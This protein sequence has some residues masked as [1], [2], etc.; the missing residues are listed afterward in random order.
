MR[1]S[2]PPK[3][4]SRRPPTS[5]QGTQASSVSPP[6]PETYPI[7]VVDDDDSI[8]ELVRHALNAE[9]HRVV[10]AGSAEE[11]HELLGGVSQPPVLVLDL[12]LPGMT[13]LE[14][15]E[16]LVEERDDFEAILLT[17]HA[18]IESLM[19]A[20]QLGVFRCLRKPFDLH[21]LRQTI[22]GAAN[23]LFLR[24]DRRAQIAEVERRN[25]E[26]TAAL[27]KLRYSESKR[28]LAERLASIGQFASALAHEINGPLSYVGANLIAARESVDDLKELIERLDRGE[29][30]TQQAP[31]LRDRARSAV[32]TATEALDDGDSGV[33]LIRQI[34]GDL[35]SVSRYRTE[36]SE[37]FDLN[38]VVRTSTRIARIDPKLP[39]QLDQRLC[40]EDVRVRGSQGRLAQVV[41]NLVANAAEA[42]EEGRPNKVTVRTTAVQDTAVLE[43]TDTGQGIPED[44]LDTIFEPFV[45]FREDGTGIGLDLVRQIV[46]EHD[47]TV[48]VDSRVGRGTTFRIVLPRVAARRSVRV[49]GNKRNSIPEG[50]NLLFVDDDPL[51][52]RAMARALPRNQVRFAADGPAALE[53]IEERPPDVIVSDLRMPEM[54][55]LTLYE[56]ISERWPEL[57]DR[58]LFVSGSTDG[59]IERAQ[60]RH[61][62]TPVLRKPIEF[63]DL[64]EKIV[65][66]NAAAE[67][68]ALR[69]A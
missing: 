29:Q 62:D 63:R 11:A 36:S 44:Q 33:Q 22:A 35:R 53:E 34:S 9:G 38:D 12:A 27:D 23:R 59:L 40:A 64:A 58:I 60:D 31:G 46:E 19:H 51:I 16:R 37:P 55:G 42:T 1:R 67:F 7:V 2:S 52:R 6:A 4:P 47:G 41:M 3:K 54:D 15:V 5:S 61:P 24:L 50:V 28:V 39:I 56:K 69:K 17:A 45:T 13:G 21:D 8:R 30:W 48:S 49:P 32:Q 68:A 66:A 57:A 14:L 43:V 65:D 25:G 26:L 18:E 20:L 10:S